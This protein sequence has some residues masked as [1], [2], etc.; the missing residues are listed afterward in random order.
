MLGERV[1]ITPVG[2]GSGALAMVGVVV[3]ILVTRIA[4]ASMAPCRSD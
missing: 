3:V 1:A 2:P 4:V